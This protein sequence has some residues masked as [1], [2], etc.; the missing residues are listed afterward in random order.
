MKEIVLFGTDKSGYDAVIEELLE[1]SNKY[2]CGTY[3]V[4]LGIAYH[5]DKMD[6]ITEVLT[7]DEHGRLV[8]LND[9]WEGQDYIVIF[10]FAPVDEIDIKTNFPFNPD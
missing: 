3:L 10:G 2:L 1:A 6:D 7:V 9:W 4:Q 8:W 5:N